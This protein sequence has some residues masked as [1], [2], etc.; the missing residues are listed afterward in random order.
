MKTTFEKINGRWVAPTGK[1]VVVDYIY[2]GD[3]YDTI[4][5]DQYIDVCTGETFA[6]E[7]DDLNS[8][9]L[10]EDVWYLVK[11]YEDFPASKLARKNQKKARRARRIDDMVGVHWDNF[12]YACNPHIGKNRFLRRRMMPN[13]EQQGVVDEYLPF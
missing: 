4:L 2:N 6:K 7:L 9:L 11:H 8:D 1:V 3:D 10:G 5:G 12:A 13:K